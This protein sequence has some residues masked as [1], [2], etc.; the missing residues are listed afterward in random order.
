MFNILL[1]IFFCTAASLFFAWVVSVHVS[2]PYIIT[3]S[4]HELYI[5]LFK[6]V[7][8]LPLKISRCLANAVHPA[9][10]L[11]CMSFFLSV[12]HAVSRSQADVAFNVLDMS[13]VDTYW[14]VV[15]HHHLCL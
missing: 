7:P 3:G 13:V 14:C 11:L 9:V 10:I 6:L 1:S 4:A 12:V 5:C 8:M 15:F 2:A